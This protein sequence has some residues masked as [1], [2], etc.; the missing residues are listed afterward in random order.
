MKKFEN[1]NPID[2]LADARVVL[3]FSDF[4]PHKNENDYLLILSDSDYLIFATRSLYI[5]KEDDGREKVRE[6][7]G[8]TKL[9]VPK[10]A[11]PW[12]I[13]AIENKF[14]KT[15]AEGA[16]PKGKYGCEEEIRGERLIISRMFGT[17]GYSFRNHSRHSYLFEDST[18]PQDMPLSDE[19][20]FEK[21]LFEE[22]KKLSIKIENGDI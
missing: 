4:M 16:I 17:P 5:F 10:A 12:F 1:I 21:G 11:L 22:L 3:V 7:I 18:Y 9:E 8:G 13:D 14:L 19:L 20:L 15:P 6:W 2:V